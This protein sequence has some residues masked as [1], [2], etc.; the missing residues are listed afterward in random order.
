MTLLFG[1]K[2]KDRH[3]RERKGVYGVIVNKEK[4][5]LTVKHRGLYFLPGGGVEGG[6]TNEQCLQREMIEEIGCE[7]ISRK[8]IGHAKRY[9]YSRKGEPLLSDGYFYKT[10]IS[11]RVQE[12]LEDDHEICWL[13][14]EEAKQLLFHDHHFWALKQVLN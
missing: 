11:E 14:V 2:E 7:V 12:P 10:W 6:E 8:Y 4:K 1:L 13:N 3:Y 9:F 5:V